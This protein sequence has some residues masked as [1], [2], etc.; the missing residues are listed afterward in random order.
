MDFDKKCLKLH[1]PT[2]EEVCKSLQASLAKNFDQCSVD[3]VDCPDL[4]SPPYS[5]A[6]IGLN[7][8]P[9]IAD[10]GGVKNLFPTP[11]K[12]KVYNIS[13]LA[14]AVE[15][16]EAF[17][18]G[19]CI[20]PF[21]VGVNSE[22]VA[23]VK[24]GTTVLNESRII[25]MDSEDGYK[26]QKLS[27]DVNT[28]T[29]MMNMFASKGLPGKV[30]RVRASKRTGEENFV[31]AMRIGLNNTFPGKTVGLGGIFRLNAGSVK[32][33]V[34]PEFSKTPLRSAE[35][36]GNWLRYFSMAAPMVF[37]S[38]FVSSDPGGLDLKLEHSHGFGA[39]NGGHYHY[40]VTPESVDYEG[41]FNV[42]EYLYRIDQATQRN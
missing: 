6:G 13:K 38:V 17:V 42:A 21:S 33:H 32:C 34:V 36:Q 28:C 26:L 41:Y 27:N 20:G 12:R 30:I 11:D 4:S 35:E 40:D 16:P 25:S 10:V 5:L 7:G 37:S 15:L 8:S 22:M 23:N 1:V 9:R 19:A 24:T 29:L 3:V 18:L 14:E 2:L 39:D 31:S